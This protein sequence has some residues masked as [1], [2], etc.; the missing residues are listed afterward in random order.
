MRVD[1]SIAFCHPNREYGDDDAEGGVADCKGEGSPK[2]LPACV[3][4]SLPPHVV[5]QRHR[6]IGMREY[7]YV[8]HHCIILMLPAHLVVVFWL[9]NSNQVPPSS[10]FVI[11]MIGWSG[12]SVN[13]VVEFGA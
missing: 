3:P 7:Y 5:L 9:H 11:W 10:I 13:T 4:T 1:N 12:W 2:V 6:I 8:V